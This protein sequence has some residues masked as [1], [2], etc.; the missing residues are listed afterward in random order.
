MRRIGDIWL[1]TTE[2]LREMCRVAEQYGADEG[3]LL[4]GMASEVREPPDGGETTEEDTW[5]TPQS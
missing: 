2:K 1:V 3:L 4:V 5:T